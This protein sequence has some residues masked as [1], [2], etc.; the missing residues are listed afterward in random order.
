M[1]RRVAIL[2]SAALL[3]AACG[4]IT[5]SQALASWAKQSNFSTNALAIVADAQHSAIA[6]RR[7]NTS[8]NDL[9]TVCAV[10]LNEVNQINA[11]LP[12]PDSQSTELLST[13]Y[14]DLGAAANLCYVA[15]ERASTRARA[16]TKLSTGVMYL[17]EGSARVTSLLRP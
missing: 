9:H 17:S 4:S 13:S 3:L 14:T 8:S 11:S 7:M 5:A 6:L 16:L 12:T 1:I 2:L 10:L 15:G